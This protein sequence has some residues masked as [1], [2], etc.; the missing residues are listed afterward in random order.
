MF[1]APRAPEAQR[2]IT[3]P[4]RIKTERKTMKNNDVNDWAMLGKELVDL[5]QARLGIPADAIKADIAIPMAVKLAKDIGSAAV[6][7]LNS[8]VAAL[9]TKNLMNQL[10]K[11]KH[12]G[13]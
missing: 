5:I 4:H 3:Q 11:G 12:H 7:S 1:R 9:Q 10:T 8:E 13:K 6:L 2:K